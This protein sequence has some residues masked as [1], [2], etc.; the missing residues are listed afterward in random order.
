MAKRQAAPFLPTQVEWRIQSC[1]EREET[2]LDFWTG[3]IVGVAGSVVAGGFSLLAA[4]ITNRSGDRAEKNRKRSEREHEFRHALETAAKA[5]RRAETRYEMGLLTPDQA[6]FEEEL[7]SVA[8]RFSRLRPEQSLWFRR[9]IERA[10]SRIM[11]GSDF[12]GGVARVD[13]LL[14]ALDAWSFNTRRPL[15]LLK[16]PWTSGRHL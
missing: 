8:W 3:L 1:W 6:P 7:V 2:H 11:D 12:S 10:L 15:N 13:F 14:E 4:A 5:V 16:A 9:E